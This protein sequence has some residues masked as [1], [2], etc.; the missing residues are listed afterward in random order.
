MGKET[1]PE[2]IEPSLFSADAVGNIWRV[3]ECVEAVVR[4]Y[5]TST[6]S[7]PGLTTPSKSLDELNWVPLTESRSNVRPPDFFAAELV[8]PVPV[9]DPLE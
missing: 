9:Q 3:I 8:I 7:A 1:V 6:S 4:L 2:R 5:I